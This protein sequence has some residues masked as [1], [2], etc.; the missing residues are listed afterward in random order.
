MDRERVIEWAAKVV[1]LRDKVAEADAEVEHFDACLEVAN[2][3]MAEATA[4]LGLAVEELSASAGE[5]VAS[6]LSRTC[7]E[8]NAEFPPERISKAT[9]RWRWRV[10][11]VGDCDDVKEFFYRSPVYA[12]LGVELGVGTQ[13]YI[14]P[15]SGRRY[16]GVWLTVE[17]HTTILA[18]TNERYPKG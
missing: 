10:I 17:E 9:R 7:W 14:T 1:A 3:N 4:A 8:R 6:A 15:K 11:R 13:E 5:A 2:A 16:K 12:S 18:L